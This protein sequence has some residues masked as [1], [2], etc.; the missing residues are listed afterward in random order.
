M[1]CR[2]TFWGVLSPQIHS[3]PTPLFIFSWVAFGASGAARMK[4]KRLGKGWMWALSANP[5]GPC[6]LSSLPV[7]ACHLPPSVL[8]TKGSLQSCRRK[9][10]CE[11][12]MD[13]GGNSRR[14]KQAFSVNKGAEAGKKK[15]NPSR[16]AKN[17]GGCVEVVFYWVG[18]F[19]NDKRKK[20]K[21]PNNP[22]LLSPFLILWPRPL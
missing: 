12:T 3:L 4:R 6:H 7:P 18:V 5:A 19:N 1:G 22:M 14:G 16:A 10:I 8:Q 15:K 11:K 21:T 17:V 20:K 2:I 13:V 9:I